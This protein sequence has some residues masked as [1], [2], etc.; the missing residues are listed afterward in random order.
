[1]ST[2]HLISEYFDGWGYGNKT[3]FLSDLH[4]IMLF[5]T[6]Q[7]RDKHREN[8]KKDRF[9]AG[10]VTPDGFGCAYTVKPDTV[11]FNVVSKGLDSEGLAFYLEQSLLDMADLCVRTETKAAPRP[12]L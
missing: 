6:S 4:L 11:Q 1:M 2:S 3:V 7:A 10:E 9:V 12:K 5:L 8:S